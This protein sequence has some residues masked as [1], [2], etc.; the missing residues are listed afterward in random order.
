MD[1]PQVRDRAAAARLFSS[2]LTLMR[3]PVLTG[4]NGCCAVTDRDVQ[5]RSRFQPLCFGWAVRIKRLKRASTWLCWWGR[6]TV[7]SDGGDSFINSLGISSGLSHRIP[8]S[9]LQ[10]SGAIVFIGISIGLRVNSTQA[11][12]PWAWSDEWIAE[13]DFAVL[14]GSRKLP[15]NNFEI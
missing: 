1:A 8:M 2:C 3:H 12:S 10:R 6:S 11:F 13:G 7:E 9:N 14:V 5:R 15:L 4:R